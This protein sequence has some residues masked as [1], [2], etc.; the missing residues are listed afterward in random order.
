[1]TEI[2]KN[3]VNIPNHLEGDIMKNEQTMEF[4]E[5]L[6]SVYEKGNSGATIQ[7]LMRLLEDELLKMSE[8]PTSEK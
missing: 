8:I 1:M 2:L 5:L 3:D 4:K 6:L 7:E